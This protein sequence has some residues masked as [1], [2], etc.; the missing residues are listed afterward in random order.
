MKETITIL[1][2]VL[3]SVYSYGQ[4]A[5]DLDVPFV[6]TTLSIVYVAAQQRHIQF[7]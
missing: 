1:I 5:R 6:G 7:S 3:L 2:I 4:R